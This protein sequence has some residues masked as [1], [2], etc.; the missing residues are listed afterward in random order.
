MTSHLVLLVLFS[1]LVSTVFA[2][3]LRDEPRAQVW[4]GLKLFG[5]FVGVGLA[6]GWLLYPMP[7]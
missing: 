5:A 7:F 1:L 3:L 6:L 2:V 4:T